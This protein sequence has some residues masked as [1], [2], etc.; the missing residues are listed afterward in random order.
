MFEAQLIL[1]EILPSSA[2]GY[3]GSLFSFS[4]VL[5]LILAL[6]VAKQTSVTDIFVKGNNFEKL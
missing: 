3:V 4:N 1:R 6:L 5:A 2:A